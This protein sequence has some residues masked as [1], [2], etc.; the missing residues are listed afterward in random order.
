MSL[1]FICR[2]YT[3]YAE[4]YQS[5]TNFISKFAPEACIMLNR[6]IWK[7]GDYNA[8]MYMCIMQNWL[9]GRTLE[10]KQ[11]QQ[12]QDVDIVFWIIHDLN[13]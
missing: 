3:D 13:W 2:R 12:I 11:I 9:I 5:C 10:N 7:L 1:R 8:A 6:T 4:I